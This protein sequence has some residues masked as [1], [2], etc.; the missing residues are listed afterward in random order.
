[1]LLAGR[2]RKAEEAEVIQETIEKYLKR[3]VNPQQLFTLSKDTSRTTLPLLREI[4]D[5]PA[6]DFQ[7]VVW[8]YNMRRMAVLVGQAL[9]FG[10]PI[11][12]VGDTG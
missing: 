11:L 2:V 9:K 4:L 1:M 7:H 10:E 6:G 12:L 5:M 3:K 8:T